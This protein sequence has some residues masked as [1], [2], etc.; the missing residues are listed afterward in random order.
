MDFSADR[1]DLCCTRGWREVQ[2]WTRFYSSYSRWRHGTAIAR[3]K[4]AGTV[5]IRVPA[6]VSFIFSHQRPDTFSFR[7]RS[8]RKRGWRAVQSCDHP[9][10]PTQQQR[11]SLSEWYGH[12]VPGLGRYSYE[13]IHF[14]DQ[15][16]NTLMST[17]RRYFM[18][19]EQ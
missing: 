14:S 16:P 7:S 5:Y 2:S 8:C 9:L 1:L 15:G 17:V 11:L 18:D 13:H 4:F 3:H 10:N 19:P 12:C 6:V